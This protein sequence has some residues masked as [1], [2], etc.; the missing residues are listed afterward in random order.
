MGTLHHQPVIDSY[1]LQKISRTHPIESRH[2][3]GQV[4]Q[5]GADLH[6]AG[7]RPGGARRPGRGVVT[8]MGAVW[9]TWEV[10]DECTKH[11]MG[12]Y[13]MGFID[14]NNRLCNYVYIY[15]YWNRMGFI[16]WDL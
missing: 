13:G 4:L 11:F 3:R 14:S 7:L 15:I 5:F 8:W 2:R 1:S 12:I 10:D 16:E 9:V 6:R